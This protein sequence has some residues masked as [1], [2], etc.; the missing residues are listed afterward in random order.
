M[1]YELCIRTESYPIW[2][3]SLDEPFMAFAAGQLIDQPGGN[4][5][6]IDEVLHTFDKSDVGEAIHRVSL[7][8]SV[9]E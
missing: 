2:K 8:V 4:P 6:R 7:I 5:F 3:A 9:E 1:V